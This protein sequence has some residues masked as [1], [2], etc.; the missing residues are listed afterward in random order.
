MTICRLTYNQS[1][2]SESKPPHGFKPASYF[3]CHSFFRMLVPLYCAIAK[4]RNNNYGGR[5]AHTSL[6]SI[7]MS[8]SSTAS[9]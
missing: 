6:C 1:R 8:L 9:T 7:Y 2:V 5:Q 4:K 3:D